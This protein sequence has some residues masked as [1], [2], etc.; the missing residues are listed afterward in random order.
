MSSNAIRILLVLLS[1][2][3]SYGNDAAK[4][5]QANDFEYSLCG[6]GATSVCCTSDQV[7]ISDIEMKGGT[8]KNVCSAERKLVGTKAIKIIIIPMICMIMDI[9]FIVYMVLK[10]DAKG[11]IVTKLCIGLI[12]VSWPLFFSQQWMFGC[13]SAFLALFVASVDYATNLPWWMPRLTWAIELFFLV[14]LFGPNEAFHAPLFSQSTGAKTDLIKTALGM[15]E[16]TCG[17]YYEKYFDILA[18]EKAALNADPSTTVFGFCTVGFLGFVQ[19]MVIFEGIY[20]MLMVLFT[21]KSFLSDDKGSNK[22]SP[23]KEP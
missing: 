8:K 13:W 15:T 7:C 18:D 4:C 10:L 19:V 21:A 23:M 9:G 3:G 12:A 20:L 11:R 22:V 5:K 1:A 17:T 6:T 16:T 2:H 14:L